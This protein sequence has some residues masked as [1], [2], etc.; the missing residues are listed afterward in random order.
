VTKHAGEQQNK[1]KVWDTCWKI[2]RVKLQEE[3]LEFKK[4]NDRNEKQIFRMI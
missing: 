4:S 2:R 3:I 1:K